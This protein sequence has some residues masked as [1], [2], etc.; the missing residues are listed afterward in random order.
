MTQLTDVGHAFF[1]AR[2][3]NILN[4]NTIYFPPTIQTHTLTHTYTH[5]DNAK[6]KLKKNKRTSCLRFVISFEFLL[7]FHR[8]RFLLLSV[9]PYTHFHMKMAFG[10]LSCDISN[11]EFKRSDVGISKQYS[12]DLFESVSLHASQTDILYTVCKAS[13][14]LFDIHVVFA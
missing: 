11:I 9:D 5:G 8:V 13:C 7:T 6:K 3:T 12:I 4:K 1:N 2:Q 14:C 10:F